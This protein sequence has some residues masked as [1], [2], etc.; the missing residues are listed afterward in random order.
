MSDAGKEEVFRFATFISAA[1]DLF[2][3]QLFS[4]ASL[5]QTP[6]QPMPAEPIDSAPSAAGELPEVSG[7][8]DFSKGINGLLPAIAQDSQTGRVLMLA[9]MDHAAFEQTVRTGQATYYSRS[10]GRAWVKGESSGH[11]QQ[12]ESIAIDCDADCIL[13][14]VRQTGAACHEG[15]RSCFFRTLESD[16]FAVTEKQVVN[17]QSVYEK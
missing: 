15:Y 9:W 10:R 2:P 6:P 13:L 11:I 7:L 4:P 16:G 5:L 8:P 1:R 12:V 17:P 14:Q 3:S